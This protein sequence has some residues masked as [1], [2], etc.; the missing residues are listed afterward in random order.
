LGRSQARFPDLLS[1]FSGA[2]SDSK[3]SIDEW[4]AALSGYA[5]IKDKNGKTI[6]ILGVDITAADVYAAQKEVRTRAILVLLLGI[7]LSVLLGMLLSRRITSPIRKLV[8]GTRHISMGDLT[9][10][11]EVVGDDEVSE[12]ASSF[13]EMIASLYESRKRVHDYFYSVIQSFARIVEARDR[14]TQGHSER[15]AKYA[16]G[17][18]LRMKFSPEEVELLK[19]TALLHDIGKLGV[20]ESILY[21]KEKLSDEEWEKIRRHPGIGE[22]ILRPVLA[23]KEML[24]AVKQHHERFDGKGY[25]NKLSGENINIFAQILSV[26]DAYDA[27]TSSRAYRPAFNKEKAIEELRKNSGTQFNPKIVE[28]F[29]QALQEEK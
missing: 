14:Y 21:K 10:K 24:A 28:A 4:G 12:L 26:A 15:V 3:L 9:Y 8:N 5:P 18:A 11:V 2:T 27:M 1:A 7:I 22:E 20:Q 25:P 17:I 6:A 19:E 29:L 16:E 13:N 23:E